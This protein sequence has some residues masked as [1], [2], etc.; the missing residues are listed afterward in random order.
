MAG[1]SEG[2]GRTPDGLAGTDGTPPPRVVEVDLDWRSVLVVL[3]AFTGV[4]ALTG[5][6]R[7][8]PRT[9]TFLGVATVLGL[10]LNPLVQVLQRRLRLPRAGAVAAVLAGGVGVVALLGLLL[11]PPAVDQAR[12]LRRELP[13]VVAELGRLPVVGDDLREAGVP[14]RVERTLAELPERLTGDTTPLER[15]ARSVADGVLAAVVTL[16]LAVTL[17]LDGERLVRAARRL[18]PPR[19]QRRAD[20]LAVLGYEV[21]GRYVAGSLL[22]AGVAGVAVLVAGLALGVPLTPLAAVW[23]A[24]WNLVPQVGGAAGGILFVA[25]GLTQGAG[26]GIACLVFFA[27]YL[28][29]E[30]HVLGPLL[31]GQAVKLSPPATMTAALVGMSSGG[32][33]GALIAVPLVGAVKAVYLELR[34]VPAQPPGPVAR[35]QAGPAR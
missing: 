22:V 20:D 12:G 15:A 16:L 14:A 23:V 33:V 5:F 7:S 28:Q 17:L 19:W 32:V 4:V 27:V 21:V 9:M 29:I 1:A 30:N 10:A 11:V 8:V 24:V 34:P 2:H 18:V 13:S 3:A 6:V 26:V 35:A 31:V 25:L